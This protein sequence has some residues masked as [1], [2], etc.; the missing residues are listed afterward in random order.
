M[1]G[2]E[3]KGDAYGPGLANESIPSFWLSDWFQEANDPKEFRAHKLKIL[4]DLFL[5]VL[6]MSFPAPQE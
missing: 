2:R 5:L 4:F 3:E 1:G 6:T